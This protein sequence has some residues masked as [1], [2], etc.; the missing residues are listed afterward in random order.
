MEDWPYLIILFASTIMGALIGIYGQ[1]L[2]EWY[3]R[4]KLSLNLEY[5][6]NELQINIVN[7]G[8]KTA[9]CA[10]VNVYYKHGEQFVKRTEDNIRIDPESVFFRV[11]GD[12]SDGHIIAENG[13]MIDTPVVILIM[14]S[15][16]DT[17]TGR[18]IYY[19]NF[20]ERPAV[21]KKRE[22]TI[23]ERSLFFGSGQKF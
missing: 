2:R 19:V 12:V 9:K 6:S 20:K 18:A 10:A 23:E 8:R 21:I 17:K 22:I 5:N 7:K 4:P 15:A 3:S 16:E 1:A 11:L 13:V 14:Y